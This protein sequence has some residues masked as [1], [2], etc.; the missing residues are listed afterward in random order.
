MASAWCRAAAWT[1]RAACMCQLLV[2]GAQAVQLRSI[3]C[4]HLP[5][6][7]AVLPPHSTGPA[8][9]RPAGH[10][11]LAWRTHQLQHQQ[12]HPACTRKSFC[13]STQVP[14]SCSR[15]CA[16]LLLGAYDCTNTAGSLAWRVQQA[17][18]HCKPARG[19]CFSPAARKSCSCKLALTAWA[20]PACQQQE[21]FVRAFGHAQAHLAA[22]SAAD[23]RNQ[24]QQAH[25]HLCRW[26]QRSAAPWAR[27]LA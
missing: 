21:P 8:T 24:P 19:C 6:V 12:T 17:V 27:P 5:A 25:P 10:A 22:G 16:S 18:C 7:P 3:C 2:A 11:R 4:M 20:G 9:C 14:V 15:A 13:C 26:Q 1:P 23:A